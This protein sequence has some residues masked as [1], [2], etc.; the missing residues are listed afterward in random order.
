MP[1]LRTA[2]RL[3]AGSITRPFASTM[4]YCCPNAAGMSRTS[5]ALQT[6]RISPYFMRYSVRLMRERTLRWLLVAACFATG[7]FAQS[8]TETYRETAARILDA[9]LA[10]Q[11]GYMKLSYLCDRIGNR[12]AGSPGLEKAIAW[13]AEQM[14]RDGL[15]NVNT[16]RVKVP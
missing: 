15:E 1:M 4:S 13:A 5:R 10:D 9:S 12:L 2:S 14:K 11:G 16:P 3:D 7:S 8:L 6:F